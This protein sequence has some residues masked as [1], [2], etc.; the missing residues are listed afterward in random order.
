MK[1]H[2]KQ[3]ERV[4]NVESAENKLKHISKLCQIA[5][6][7]SIIG[8][9]FAGAVY[10][11]IARDTLPFIYGFGFGAGLSVVP[12][13]GA[14]IV[15]NRLCRIAENRLCRLY[16]QRLAARNYRGAKR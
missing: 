14:I 9:S 8:G 3:Y 10:S 1:L 2:N 15:E 4:E 7:T 6:A 11:G 5:V 16:E 13:I 12:A